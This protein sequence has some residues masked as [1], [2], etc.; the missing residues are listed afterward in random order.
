MVQPSAGRRDRSRNTRGMAASPHRRPSLQIACYDP[1]RVVDP[2]GLNVLE[3]TT[4]EPGDKALRHRLVA[5]IPLTDDT[6]TAW[7]SNVTGRSAGRNANVK[8][9]TRDQEEGRLAAPLSIVTRA[10]RRPALPALRRV[11][12]APPPGRSPWPRARSGRA[13]G[14]W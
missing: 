5:E 12:P 6:G 8:W 2:P 3:R 10:A 4:S 9:P 13:P 1:V 7:L 14:R 11:P